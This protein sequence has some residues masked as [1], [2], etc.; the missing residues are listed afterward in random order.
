M[1][2][3]ITSHMIDLI[4]FGQFNIITYFD[5]KLFLI[6]HHR[7]LLNLLSQLLQSTFAINPY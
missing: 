2:S 1:I 4:R 5:I 3:Y 6:I 7:H